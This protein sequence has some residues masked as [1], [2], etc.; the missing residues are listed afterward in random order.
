MLQVILNDITT[1]GPTV[2]SVAL[3]VIGAAAVAAAHLPKAGA[4]AT[5]WW[6]MARAVL[7]Y[8]AQ[9]YKNAANK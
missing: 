4:N 3:T 1:Y 8:V 7:D 5:A 6:A 2:V 9:N